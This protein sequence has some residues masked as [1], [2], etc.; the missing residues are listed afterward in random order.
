MKIYING[1]AD[2]ETKRSPLSIHPSAA[3]LHMGR[4]E[5]VTNGW[6]YPL[7]GAMDQ[8]KIYNRALSTQEVEADYNLAFVGIKK[9]PAA[10][11]CLLQAYPIPFSDET[12]IRYKTTV[13]GRVSISIYNMSG[14]KIRTLVSATQQAD[15]HSVTW[16]GTETG[17]EPAGSGVYSCT[18]YVDDQPVG[19]TK[20]VLLR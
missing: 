13:A 2:P 1:V 11:N 4:G 9:K 8:V 14:Q 3:D 5:F 19:R 12:T 18:I 6:D 15:D 20:L 16:D 10:E 7:N 17:G